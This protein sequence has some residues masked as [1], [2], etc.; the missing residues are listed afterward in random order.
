MP[1]Y[2]DR[3]RY[4]KKRLS[5]KEKQLERLTGIIGKSEIFHF[6]YFGSYSCGSLR[7]TK[8]P[9]AY[10]YIGCTKPYSRLWISSMTEQSIRDGFANLR[11]C[12]DYDNMFAAGITRAKIDWLWGMNLTR[13]YTR[14][15]GA[16]CP[17]GRVQTAV[18]NMIVS[19]LTSN[20]YSVSV[21]SY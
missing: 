17:V 13:L 21:Y 2:N 20:T 1:T 19:P 16:L 4:Q 9:L 7:R 8:C 11:P 10:D 5:D 15:L 18:V 6:S 14:H 12:S 3:L